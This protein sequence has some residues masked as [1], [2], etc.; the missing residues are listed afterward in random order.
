MRS[1]ADPMLGLGAGKS[2][3]QTALPWP[4]AVLAIAGLCSAG[5]F[6]VFEVVTRIL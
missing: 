6:V 3:I 2:R 4:V 5:W 1:S